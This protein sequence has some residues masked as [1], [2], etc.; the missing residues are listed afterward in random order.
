MNSKT[1]NLLISSNDTYVFPTMVLLDSFCKNN[2][3]DVNVFFLYN[4]L[5]SQNIEKINLLEDRYSY[6]H[7]TYVFVPLEIFKNAP[8]GGVTNDYI[9]IETYFRLAVTELLPKELTRILYLD[10]DMVINGSLLGFY[11]HDFKNGSVALVCEDYGLVIADKLRKKVYNNLSLDS[12]HIY[13]NAGVMLFNLIELREKYSLE[14]FIEFI[15]Q[16]RGKLIFH[17]QDILN[18]MFTNH[19]EYADYDKYNCRPFYYPFSAKSKQIIS[20][21]IIIHYGEKPWNAD[22]TDMGG[23]IYW[24]YANTLVGEHRKIELQKAH[25]EYIAQN[26]FSIFIKKI[27]RNIKLTFLVK[28]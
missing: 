26:W 1:M 16:N 6:L 20:S 14:L 25:D 18:A 2:Q 17:D 3:L 5:S 8:L 4:K 27:K 23:E 21:A 22:F 10:T 24:K 7:I 9:S 15:E 13:F 11:N 28:R 19:L 12:E